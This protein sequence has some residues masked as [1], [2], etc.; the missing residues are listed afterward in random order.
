VSFCIQSKYVKCRQ[1]ICSAEQAAGYFSKDMLIATFH[2][3]YQ[4]DTIRY[5]HTH[6]NKQK[7]TGPIPRTGQSRWRLITFSEQHRDNDYSWYI[8]N[9]QLLL[10]LH[11][12]RTAT[13][14]GIPALSWVENL[15]AFYIHCTHLPYLQYRTKIYCTVRILCHGLYMYIRGQ[16]QV[17]NYLKYL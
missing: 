2:C 10:T 11:N 6:S 5:L 3:T 17:F 13:P 14:R 7:Q 4:T 12:K 15:Q 9:R 1:P 8:T 16:V